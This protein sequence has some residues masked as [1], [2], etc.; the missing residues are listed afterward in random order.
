MRKATLLLLAATTL[1]ALTAMGAPPKGSPT[2]FADENLIAWCIV[3]F[4]AKHRGP[5]ER[6][7]MLQ[8]LGFQ[9]FAYDW[10]PEH[11]PTFDAEIEAM[12]Q[13]KIELTAWWFPPALN[14]DAVK[15]LAALKRHDVKTQLWVAIDA[16]P[17]PQSN[18]QRVK[19]AAAAKILRPIVEAAAAQ[20]CTVGL[21]NHGGWFGDL[22]N[23]L[24]II[25][26]L[27]AP[28]LGI[29][30]NLHH[31]HDHLDR[32]ASLLEKMKP[33]LYAITLNGMDRDGERRGRKILPLGQ[34]ELDLPL[35]RTIKDSG[36]TGP[37]AI[38]GHTEDDAELRLKDNLEGLTW[39]VKQLE[40][41][42]PAKR[43]APRTPV[44]SATTSR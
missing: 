27:D 23:Q 12:K 41:Q 25:A 39:L 15:I 24:A 34:G 20:G 42:P 37:L 26:A 43:P 18:E 1:S 17:A 13:A 36:Y 21:Y 7:A 31:G 32:F 40:G 5:A 14:E 38:L 28:N 29:V 44:P 19:V 33:H 16:D 8:R 11:I 4:D 6:A 35:L 9:K 30:Y 10:R 2:L 22:E 3:P